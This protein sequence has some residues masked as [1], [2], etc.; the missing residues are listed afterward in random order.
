MSLT[1]LSSLTPTTHPLSLNC[2]Y[3][4]ARPPN[5]SCTTVAV[6]IALA[7]HVSLRFT[8]AIATSFT[9]LKPLSPCCSP[10][11]LACSVPLVSCT[12]LTVSPL[13]HCTQST[14]SSVSIVSIGLCHLCDRDITF[15]GNTR[16]GDPYRSFGVIVAVSAPKPRLMRLLHPP[17]TFSFRTILHSALD[18]QHQNSEAQQANHQPHR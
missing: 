2:I 8:A 5:L 14:T 7:V 18:R 6:A 17:P 15:N 12:V 11:A 1:I 4:P 16:C 13:Q 9:F 10:H 3:G